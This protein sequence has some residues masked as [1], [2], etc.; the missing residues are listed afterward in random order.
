MKY[1][2][3]FSTIVQHAEAEAPKE[4]CGLLLRTES[5]GGY[6]VWACRNAHADP[7]NFFQIP[8]KDHLAAVATGRLVA[9]YHS[10]P[11]TGHQFS[12]ADLAVSEAA[13]LPLYVYSLVTQRFSLHEPTGRP[14]PLE[15]RFFVFGLHDCAGLVMDY[16]RQRLNILMPEM[17]GE[18]RQMKHLTDGFPRMDDYL[19]RAGFVTVP[20]PVE[21]SVVLMSL[22]GNGLINHCAVMVKD[23]NILHQLMYRTSRL[24]Q[25]GGYWQERTV[26]VVKHQS[27]L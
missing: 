8:V 20:T 26:K 15:G 19:E 7:E 1:P 25:Y 17:T 18:E 4:C 3:V 2:S 9:Y 6:D 10:H 24:D 27:L 23:G 16:H 13:C 11:K 14:V 12:P 22:T 5:G 21:H